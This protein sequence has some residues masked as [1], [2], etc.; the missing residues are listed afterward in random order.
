MEILLENTNIIYPVVGG[1]LIGLA[2]ISL[3]LFNGRIAGIS[4]I[5]KGALRTLKNDLY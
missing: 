3:I 1:V 4:G 2:S 5:V